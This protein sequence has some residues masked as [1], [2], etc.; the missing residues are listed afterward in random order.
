[1]TTA[2]TQSQ[3]IQDVAEAI[4][5]AYERGA[6]IAPVREQLGDDSLITEGDNSIA[7]R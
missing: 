6:P 2:L 1:M 7:D 3:T 5:A 4:R